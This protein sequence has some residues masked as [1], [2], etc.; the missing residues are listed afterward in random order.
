[1]FRFRLLTL[2]IVVSVIAVMTAYF[3]HRHRIAKQALTSLTVNGH[4]YADGR[5]V[6]I[7]IAG[8]SLGR[9]TVVLICDRQREKPSD[10]LPTLKSDVSLKTHYPPDSSVSGIWIDG[11]QQ[12]IGNNLLVVYVSAI[13]KA[14]ILTIPEESNRDFLADAATLDP[15]QFVDRWVEPNHS[16]PN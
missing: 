8:N 13:S 15:A 4:G 16:R 2:F 10:L 3:A 12:T 11:R 7:Q 5:E 14:K 6:D 9:S 1:M